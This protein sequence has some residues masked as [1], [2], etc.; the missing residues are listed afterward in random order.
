MLSV[1]YG[2]RETHVA[3]SLESAFADG[4][5]AA[6]LVSNGHNSA[7][8]GAIA[9]YG[10]RVKLIELDRNRGSAI[11]YRHAIE[12]AFS[13]CGDYFWLMDDDNAATAGSLSRLLDG[14]IRLTAEVGREHAAVLGYRND[15]LTDL[16]RGIPV[17]IAF[18]SC[19]SFMGFDIRQL[20]FKVRRRA[21]QMKLRPLGHDDTV[22]VPYAPYGGLIAHRE[23]Y[24]RIG[25]PLEDLILYGDDHEYTLRITEHGGVIRLFRGAEVIDLESSWF[26]DDVQLNKNERR[27][28]FDRLIQDGSDFR[29]Y[30]QVRN[31]VW[32]DTHRSKGAATL[33]RANKLAFL[34]LL[35]RASRRLGGS[36][37]L[38]LIELAIAHGERGR[39]GENATFPLP[40]VAA[41]QEPM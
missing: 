29:I 38:R 41:L 7:L 13:T 8:Q 1:T 4:V 26:V 12:T 28:S 18:P 40:G 24:N 32:F 35:R 17:S 22:D 5:G 25:L 30:Y 16:G 39:L 27:T 11:G 3:R 20:W 23:C 34:L 14:L 33:R 36:G 19:G 31:R 10:D 37:R 9:Q 2:N 15:H 21:F 6:V